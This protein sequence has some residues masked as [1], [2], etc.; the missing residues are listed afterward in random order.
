MHCAEIGNSAQKL[1]DKHDFK[2]NQLL[3]IEIF[4]NYTIFLSDHIKWTYSNFLYEL[5][6]FSHQIITVVFPTLNARKLADLLYME[7]G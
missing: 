2:P 5:L 4:W 6:F 3:H 7:N 1:V